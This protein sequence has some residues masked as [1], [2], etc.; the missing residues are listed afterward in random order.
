LFPDCYITQPDL[1]AS[2]A[3]DCPMSQEVRPKDMAPIGV[4]IL[5]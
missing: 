3:Q 5:I 1:T 2:R 4:S